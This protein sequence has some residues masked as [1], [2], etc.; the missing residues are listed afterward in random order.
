MARLRTI[1]SSQI[2]WNSAGASSLQPGRSNSLSVLANISLPSSRAGPS[3]I[4]L[5]V[6][7]QFC[8]GETKKGEDGRP[9]SLEFG[10]L[11][12]I[13]GRPSRGRPFL[14]RP[15]SAAL[16]ASMSTQTNLRPSL[17]SRNATR[18]SVSANRV[19][20]LPMPTFVAR[21]ILGAALAHDDVA[22]ERRPRRRTSSRRGACL[23]VATVARRT[24]C[25]LMCHDEL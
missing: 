10:P 8:E 15:Y 1:R 17:P 14:G 2:A 21:I 24:A 6:R 20:S 9:L 3:P 25:F 4:G 16:V 19:W 7:R 13:L 23:R 12:R 5:T 22:G 18:P 11:A